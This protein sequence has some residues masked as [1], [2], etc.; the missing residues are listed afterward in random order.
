MK[1][2]DRVER[3]SGDHAG[4]QG[5]IIELA[6]IDSRARVLWTSHKDGS[7][8]KVRTWVRLSDLKIINS[9]D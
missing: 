5:T 8:I 7:T 6:K 2:N 4:R 1:I 3:L 9:N